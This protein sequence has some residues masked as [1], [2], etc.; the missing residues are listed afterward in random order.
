MARTALDDLIDIYREAQ[1]ALVKIITGNTGAGTKTYYNSVLKQTEAL[2]NRLSAQTGRYINTEIPKEYKAA[3]ESTYDY[4]KRNRLQMKRPDIFAQV[5]AD[6]VSELAAEMQHHINEGISNAGRRVI[7][8]ADS[9]M[10][11]ALRQNGLRAS[12]VKI[13]SGQTV[14]DMQKDLVQRL[15]EDGFLTVQYGYG[16]GAYQ[17]GLDSYASMVARSTTREAGNLARE[18]QLTDKFDLS[19]YVGWSGRREKYFWQQ[20]NTSGG[21]TVENW[22][23]LAASKNSPTTS[24]DEIRL[25]K[26]AWYGDISLS[27]DNWAYLEATLR[28]EKSSTLFK[29]N[30]SFWYPSVSGSIIYSELLKDKRP[31]WLDYGKVRLSYGVVG[32]APDAYYATQAFNQGTAHSYVYNEQPSSVGNNNLKPEKTYEWEIGWEN[33]FLHDRVGFDFSYYHKDIKDQI[34][35]TTMPASSGAKSIAMNVGEFTSKGVELALYGTPLLTKDWR[36]DVRFNIA[37]NTNKVKKLA[38]GIDRLEHKRWDNGAVYL[39]STVGGSIGDF[40]AYA[41]QTDE[42]GNYIVDASTGWYKLTD[43]PVK[44]GNA[45]PK[46]TGGAGVTVSWKNLALDVTLSYRHGGSIFNMPY[47]YMMGRGAIEESMDYRDEAHGGQSYYIDNSVGNG[48]VPAA[49]APAGKTL[50]HDGMILPGV[51]SDNGQPNDIMIS[52]MR[53]YNWSYNWGT[54]A[55][56]YYS[57]SIFK[58]SYVKVREIALSYSFPKLITDK[59]HM[60]RLVVSAYARNPFYIYKNL[61]IFDAEATDATSWIEQS[62]IGGSTAT[63]RSFGVSLKAC[64]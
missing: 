16:K 44:V 47:E 41:P 49:T 59:L 55:P 48:I 34:L 45:M 35:S 18:K 21:L 3:L 53:W 60:T 15:S 2:L 52:A 25:L 37:W 56:T 7:R 62:W 1:L 29:D 51:R 22:F 43:E 28:N 31:S 14:R 38:E 54:D 17:V 42:N 19:A 64:F 63:T 11:N 13:A 23:N 40:Y 9:A 50:Y 26:T 4:F 20:S 61:P 57:H 36:I 12:A 24:E 33:K 27:W 6:A 8:Y 46:Y 58:N 39:Y 5:H 10:D 32:L 30:N